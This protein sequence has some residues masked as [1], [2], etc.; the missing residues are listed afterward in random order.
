MIK[1]L[2]T[3]FAIV[4]L[5]LAVLIPVSTPLVVAQADVKCGATGTLVGCDEADGASAG[6]DDQVSNLINL[7][8]RIFQFVV[9]LIS[10]FMIIAGGLK[11]ITS[12]GDSGKV[13][14]AKNAILYAVIGL[15]IVGIAEVI[16]RFALNRAVDTASNT[17]L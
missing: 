5:Q 11:Y 14:E 17:I 2:T 16:V 1:R 6:V 8:I 12:G 3:F 9:G 15:V 7:A 13:G 4:A 10:I